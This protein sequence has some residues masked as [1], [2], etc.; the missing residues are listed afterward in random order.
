MAKAHAPQKY[1]ALSPCMPPPVCISIDSTYWLQ[2]RRRRTQR[3]RKKENRFGALFV[4]T[5]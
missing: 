5:A 2:N 3:K 4:T 1:G